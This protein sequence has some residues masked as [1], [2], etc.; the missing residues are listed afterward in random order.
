MTSV[1]PSPSS[2][3][4]VSSSSSS[5]S[6]SY[7]QN[8]LNQTTSTSLHYV[9]LSHSLTIAA[10]SSKINEKLIK[11]N[12]E[13]NFI[14][15][16]YTGE[17]AIE[18]HQ[19]QQQQQLCVKIC[20]CCKVFL[21][22]GYNLKTRIVYIGNKKKIKKNQNVKSLSNKHV[23]DK[24]HEEWKPRKRVL[25]YE[26]LHCDN[27]IDFDDIL[28]QPSSSLE[29]KKNAPIFEKAQETTSS[30]PFIATWNASKDSNSGTRSD[31]ANNV[32]N[33][34]NSTAKE[35]SKK[36][37]KLN[38]LSNLLQDKKKQNNDSG[39]KISGLNLMDFMDFGKQ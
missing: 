20:P 14:L 33:K 31:T 5:L 37:K 9:N 27:R 12:R 4:Q 21:I 22:P 25:R 17:N 18:K 6:T 13:K 3:L 32:N 29:N 24:D 2:P 30:T 8:Q 38:S 36:R 1:S 35:R 26:C 16:F 10:L 7:K 11:Y 23:N 28:L 39:K 19:Q 15:P 34:K